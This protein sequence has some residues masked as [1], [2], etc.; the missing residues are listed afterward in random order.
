MK[1]TSKISKNLLCFITLL[2]LSSSSLIG[3]EIKIGISAALS[4]NNK[5]IGKFYSTGA[6]Y[7]LNNAI[8]NNEF[9]PYTIKILLKDDMY[10]PEKAIQNTLEF[11]KDEKVDY[12]FGYVGTPTTFN[13]TPLLPRFNQ[14]LYFPYTG[15]TILILPPQKNFVSIFRP[16]YKEEVRKLYN[17]FKSQ[18]LNK[19][20]IFFQQDSY[21]TTGLSAMKTILKKENK[22]PF[23]EIAYKR[24]KA[25]SESFEKEANLITK[26]NPDALIC[27][28]TYEA[29][30]GIIRDLRKMKSQLPIATISFS[31][32]EKVRSIITQTNAEYFQNLI[33]SDISSE[34]EK[35]IALDKYLHHTKGVFENTEYEGFLAGLAF[36]E[37]LKFKLGISEKDT[38]SKVDI[39]LPYT[40]DLNKSPSLKNVYLSTSQNGNWVY[41][42]N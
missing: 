21:G 34:N 4:G 16:S 33:H 8:K 1:F 36:V 31:D 27:I 25:Y 38:L 10:N 9:K 23:L 22:K 24:G 14:H 35:S 30:A 12:L 11:L 32:K 37:V 3:K 39:G 17:Y 40:I 13:V 20:A 26:A 15:A 18:N 42:N 5:F 19:I 6:L 41:L 2:V 28:S 7:A 29:S